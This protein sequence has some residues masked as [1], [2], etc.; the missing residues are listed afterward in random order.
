MYRRTTAKVQKVSPDLSEITVRLPISWKNK[1]YVGTIFGGSMFSAVD[2]IPMVQ[3]INLLGSDYV[4]WDK[5][6]EIKFKRPANEDLFAHFLFQKEE[7]EAIKKKVAQEKEIEIVK[8]TILKD[9]LGIKEFCT[10]NKTIYIANKSYYKEKR[11]R[12][13]QSYK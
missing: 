4:V 10:I 7:I 11:Q 13:D 12:K 6:A 1:N 5:S 2:P 9:G 8:S 3:L